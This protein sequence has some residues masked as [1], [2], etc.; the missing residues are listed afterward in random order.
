MYTDAIPVGLIY[1]ESGVSHRLCGSGNRKVD[2]S[3]HLARLFFLYE[4]QRV[5]VLDLCRKPNRM[6]GQVE[7][8]DLCHATAARQQPFPD[9]RDGLSHSADKPDAGYDN[10]PSAR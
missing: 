6:A 5:E 8:L 7:G 2:E 4:D 10:S 1:L 3:A 9:L